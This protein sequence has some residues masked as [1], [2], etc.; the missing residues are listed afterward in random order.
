MIYDQEG[1]TPAP[2]SRPPNATI[3]KAIPSSRWPVPKWPC[4]EFPLE[5]P[6]YLRAQDIAMV[7]KIELKKDKKGNRDR[8]DD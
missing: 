8:D 5:R 2:R 6:D 3:S 1:D 7:S 4:A